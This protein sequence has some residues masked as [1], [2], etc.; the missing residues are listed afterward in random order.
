MSS[1]MPCEMPR[2]VYNKKKRIRAQ[3]LKEEARE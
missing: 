3:R 2:N 1:S